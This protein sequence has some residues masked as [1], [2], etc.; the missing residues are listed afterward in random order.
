MT[1][2]DIDVERESEVQYIGTTPVFRPR[3]AKWDDDIDQPIV[4]ATSDDW[5]YDSKAKRLCF[6]CMVNLAVSGSIR[7]EPCNYKRNRRLAVK[8]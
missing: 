4:E 2:L 7:C 3:N 1:L 5:Y 8:V 6:E